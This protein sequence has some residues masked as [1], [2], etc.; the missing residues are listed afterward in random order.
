MQ[1][2]TFLFLALAAMIV[3]V[4]AMF[5]PVP[6]LRRRSMWRRGLRIETQYYI[7]ASFLQRPGWPAQAGALSYSLPIQLF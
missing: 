7:K 6:K 5:F 2:I 4:Y 1:P 3:G